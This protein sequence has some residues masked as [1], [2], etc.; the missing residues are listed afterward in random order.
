[1]SR[2]TK[3]II[4]T[5]IIILLVF[6]IILAVYNHMKAEP[7]D[8]EVTNGNILDDANTGL[9]NLINDI[10]NEEDQEEEKDEENVK[11]STTNTQVSNTQNSNKTTQEDNNYVE[12]QNTPGEK[13]A[14][15][16]VKAEWKKEWGDLEGVSFY[17]VTIQNDGKYVVCVRD[18]KTT[19]ELKRYVIDTSTGVVQEK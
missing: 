10:F 4:I 7:M 1:M 8:A 13:K 15:E 18:S 12:E 5:I 9:E 14:I 6:S 17:D 16:L 11:N 3:Y 2:T 19:N